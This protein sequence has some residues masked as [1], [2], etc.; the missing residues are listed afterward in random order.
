MSRG[1]LNKWVLKGEC[2][3]DYKFFEVNYILFGLL[4][5]FIIW[6]IVDVELRVCKI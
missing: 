4:L 2:F 5:C 3:F 6:Y 1:L